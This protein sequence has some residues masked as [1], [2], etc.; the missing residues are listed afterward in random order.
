MPRTLRNLAVSGIGWNSSAAASAVAIQIAQIAILARMLAPEDFG[1]MTSVMVFIGLGLVFADLGSSNA[2]VVSGKSSNDQLNSLFWLILLMGAF[3]FTLSV[4]V[5]PAICALSGKP[6]L[7]SPLRWTALIFPLAAPGQLFKALL[8]R[9]LRFQSLAIAEVL[10]ALAGTFAAVCAAFHSMG[11]FALVIGQLT[12]WLLKSAVYVFAGCVVWRP[13]IRLSLSDAMEF[14]KFGMFQMAERAV[15]YLSS[16]VDYILV[17]QLLGSRILGVYS[18]VYQLVTV[19]LTRINPVFTSVAFP[20]MARQHADDTALRNGYLETI[21]LV[22]MIVFPLLLGL[23][24]SA[25]LFVQVVYGSGWNLAIPL[26]EILSILGI[27][28]SVSN[29]SGFILLVKNRPDIGFA[30]N[31]FVA[32]VNTFVFWIA[33]QN[34]VFALAWSW[35]ALTSVYSIANLWILSRMIELSWTRVIWVLARPALAGSG[36]GGATLAMRLV[37][38]ELPLSPAFAL[39]CSVTSGAIAFVALVMWLDKPYLAQV[40]DFLSPKETR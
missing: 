32:I 29:P 20:V 5:T 23:L 36:A 31:T 9:E 30:W 34:G 26:I 13:S 24:A 3:L 18:V 28:K 25:P 11:V 35:V 40:R 8:Q 6:E 15:N 21:K 10:P 14:A 17:G 4:V 12:N 37:L 1:T 16:N 22:A 19:P 39:V 38:Q 2:V 27:L 7:E 33:V